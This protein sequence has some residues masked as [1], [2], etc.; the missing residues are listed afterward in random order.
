M[1][2]RIK[3]RRPYGKMRFFSEKVDKTDKPFT[4]QEKKRQGFI[5]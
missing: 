1:K 3:N 5:Y 4:E 2:Y